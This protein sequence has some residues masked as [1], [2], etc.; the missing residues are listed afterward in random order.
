[1]R[2]LSELLTLG[3]IKFEEKKILKIRKNSATN[4]GILFVVNGAY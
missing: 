1:M 3:P 4:K 2:D